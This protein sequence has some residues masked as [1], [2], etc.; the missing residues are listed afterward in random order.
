[1]FIDCTF[2]FCKSSN[3][4][5]DSSEY[6]ISS[7]Q[8]LW[9]NQKSALFEAVITT[10]CRQIPGQINDKYMIMII[11]ENTLLV[12]DPIAHVNY[13][14]LIYSVEIIYQNILIYSYMVCHIIVV[15]QAAFIKLCICS[16]FTR[17]YILHDICNVM[18]LFEY[19][20][21]YNTHI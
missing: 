5:T 9:T 10:H 15:N 17:W 20:I 2:L 11:I 8:L 19:R 18:C 21:T 16:L 13:K 7:A 3:T 14:R 12:F 4:V 1:M 6:T